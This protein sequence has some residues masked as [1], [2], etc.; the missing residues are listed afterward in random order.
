[1]VTLEENTIQGGAGH[2]VALCA[3]RHSL[4]TPL[5]HLGL[6]DQYIEHASREQQL[7]ITGL[8][9]QGVLSAIEH[10]WVQLFN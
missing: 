9:A 3:M 5:L 1:V 8:D 6:P 7:A 4:T 10:Q 2:A